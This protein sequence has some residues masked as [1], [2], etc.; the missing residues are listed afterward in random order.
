MLGLRFEEDSQFALVVR[1]AN[2]MLRIR[3]IAPLVDILPGPS[4]LAHFPL[5][6][7]AVE[8]GWP[9]ALD[10]KRRVLQNLVPHDARHEVLVL[11]G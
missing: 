10:K 7:K 11:L 5:G 9:L 1:T 3:K 2:A 6:C 8:E 4:W